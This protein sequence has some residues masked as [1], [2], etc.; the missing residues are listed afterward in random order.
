MI[1]KWVRQLYS[2]LVFDPMGK[3]VPTIEE[4]WEKMFKD[5]SKFGK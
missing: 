3:E 2:Y 1:P 4:R 5:R